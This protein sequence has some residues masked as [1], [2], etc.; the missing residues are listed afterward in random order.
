MMNETENKLL[1]QLY[2]KLLSP[3][4]ADRW[5]YTK[6]DFGSKYEIKLEGISDVINGYTIVGVVSNHESEKFLTI[7]SPTGARIYD[8]TVG[9]GVIH[10]LYS[11]LE[12]RHVSAEQLKVQ[13]EEQQRCAPLEQLLA[14]LGGKTKKP[15]RKKVRS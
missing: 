8:S 3:E 9:L 7:T 12:Q 6:G 10:E 13:Q 15:S 1:E 2:K 11:I 14:A 5:N 4:L